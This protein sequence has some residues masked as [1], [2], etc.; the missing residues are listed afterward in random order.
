MKLAFTIGC[1]DKMPCIEVVSDIAVMISNSYCLEFYSFR[2]FV[3][4]LNGVVG[5]Q[6]EYKMKS[7]GIGDKNNEFY[8]FA[9]H[10]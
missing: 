6:K 1:Q 4:V 8:I 2:V 5:R 7:N 3:W 9:L 10:S